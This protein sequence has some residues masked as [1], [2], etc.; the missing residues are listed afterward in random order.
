MNSAL[1]FYIKML[2][3]SSVKKTAVTLCTIS[4]EVTHDQ[5]TRALNTD[6]FWQTLLEFIT[7]PFRLRGGYLIIDN[8]A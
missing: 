2:I 6:G 5:L 7:K 3:I 1:I 4:D 8:T